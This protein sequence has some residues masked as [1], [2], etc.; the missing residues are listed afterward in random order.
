MKSNLQIVS[1]EHE[2]VWAGYPSLKIF[3]KYIIG[4]KICASPTRALAAV[5]NIIGFNLASLG[6]LGAAVLAVIRLNGK[7]SSQ[8][9]IVERKSHA[10]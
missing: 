1:P 9:K 10:T 6:H 4:G 5:I 3:N 8:K 2:S 7:N